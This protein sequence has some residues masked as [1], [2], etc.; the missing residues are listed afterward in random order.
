M[1]AVD[2]FPGDARRNVREITEVRHDL[3]MLFKSWRLGGSISVRI[4]RQDV[5]ECSIHDADG[6]C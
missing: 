2:S 4:E 3:G 6:R 1:L 5:R